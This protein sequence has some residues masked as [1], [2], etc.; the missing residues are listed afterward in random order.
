MRQFLVDSG[1]LLALIDADDQH[2]AAA[3]V[4][5]RSNATATFHVPETVFIETMV[6]TKAR[7]GAKAA[8]DL[9]SRIIAS[10][11]VRVVYWTTEDRQITW[12][13]FSRYTDKDSPSWQ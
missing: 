10:S 6:L 7:L 4:F 9:G 1:A 11:H 13:I 12:D 5:A 3:A 8:V 2:H